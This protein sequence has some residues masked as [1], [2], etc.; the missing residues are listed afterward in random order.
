MDALSVDKMDVIGAVMMA[1]LR[2]RNSVA[3]MDDYVAETMVAMLV[4]D[5]AAVMDVMSAGNLVARH[6]PWQDKPKG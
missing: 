1:A 5:M 6:R 3:P 4:V 2:G